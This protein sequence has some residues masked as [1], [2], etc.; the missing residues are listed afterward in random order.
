MQN[1]NTCSLNNINYYEINTFKIFNINISVLRYVITQLKLIFFFRKI[2]CDLFPHTRCSILIL[3]IFFSSFLIIKSFI[4][5]LIVKRNKFSFLLINFVSIY[6]HFLS[7]SK[8]SKSIK[9]Y[10][11]IYLS[12]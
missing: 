10:N 5:L 9:S 4:F 6:V 3:M 8:N 7:K 1:Q 12:L 2:L 11:F